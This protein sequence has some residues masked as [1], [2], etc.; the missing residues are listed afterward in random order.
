MGKKGSRMMEKI[1]DLTLEVII[2]VTGEDSVSLM[3]D[4]GLWTNKEE[5]Q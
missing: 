3:Y 4:V 1:L 2:L 5:A